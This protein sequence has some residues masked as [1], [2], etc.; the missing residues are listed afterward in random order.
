MQIF[1]SWTEGNDMICIIAQT[2][3]K[4][5]CSSVH[6]IEIEDCNLFITAIKESIEYSVFQLITWCML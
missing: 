3:L 1:Q 2:Y 5:P 6:W 4:Y